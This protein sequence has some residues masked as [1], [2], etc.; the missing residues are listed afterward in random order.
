MAVAA[1]PV[2]V[3]F[4]DIDAACPMKSSKARKHIRPKPMGRTR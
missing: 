1:I 3:S 4:Q 2:S